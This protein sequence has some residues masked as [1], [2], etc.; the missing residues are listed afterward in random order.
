MTDG[1]EGGYRAKSGNLREGLGRGGGGGGGRE[2]TERSR[3]I[4]GR[5]GTERSRV[6][7]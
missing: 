1:R 2:G 7:S 3:V 6:T 4:R 5:E